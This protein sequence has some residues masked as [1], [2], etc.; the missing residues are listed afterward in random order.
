MPHP[1]SFQICRGPWIAEGSPRATLKFSKGV[2][3]VQQPWA[4]DIRGGMRRNKYAWTFQASQPLF[5]FLTISA[6]QIWSLS[7][8]STSSLSHLNSRKTSLHERGNKFSLLILYSYLDGYKQSGLHGGKPTC[9]SSQPRE[10][11]LGKAYAYPC[12]YT[13]L[14]LYVQICPQA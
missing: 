14:H 6:S 11:P 3:F 2:K 7:V 12:T 10:E 8:D 9:S 1:L 13:Y 5:F 4:Q